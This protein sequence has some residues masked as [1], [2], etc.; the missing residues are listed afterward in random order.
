MLNT[1][2]AIIVA[3]TSFVPATVIAGNGGWDPAQTKIDCRPL[4]EMLDALKKEND[5]VPVG[6]GIVGDSASGVRLL[7]LSSPH[8]E[9][10][11]IVAVMPAANR[12]CMGNF[13]T[14]WTT[15]NSVRELLD[16]PVPATP[17]K[18]PG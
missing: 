16:T 3:C 13:G 4:D 11:S 1:A 5:E 15:G 14:N 10:F 2:A 6:V 7:L 8:G 12:A 18:P 9:T 17:P